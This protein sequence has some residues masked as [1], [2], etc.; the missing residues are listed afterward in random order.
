M[1]ALGRVD[2]SLVQVVQYGF[3][4]QAMALTVDARER[5]LIEVLAKREVDH[6]VATLPLGDIC[7][8]SD[9]GTW[10][11]ERK[12]TDDLA[13]SIKSG[14]WGEQLG[15]LF[16]SHAACIV[17]IFEGDLRNTSISYWSV[18]GAVV[19]AELRKNAHV[20][21]TWDVGETANLVC[22]L[23]GKLAA[24]PPALPSSL[25]PPTLSKR[26]R[27]SEVQTVHVRQLMCIP[28]ISENIARKL[29]AQFGTVAALQRALAASG[30]FPCVSLNK[31]S[32]LGEARLAKLRCYLT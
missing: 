1:K 31:R 18:L 26:K 32:C 16:S 19:N 24:P 30:E 15:R 21:R 10:L 5:A 29:L 8:S 7:Y 20:F 23:I 3:L 2:V 13:Q 22:H 28:S 14:R 6:T 17:L 27:D 25:G 9:C 4:P 12:R 11:A